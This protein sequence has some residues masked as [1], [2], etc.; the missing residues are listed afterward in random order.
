MDGMRSGFLFAG[1]SYIV[2]LGHA[3]GSRRMGLGHPL[4]VISHRDSALGRPG[5]FL[6]P[7][8]AQPECEGDRQ[9]G[10]QTK[11]GHRILRM[12]VGQVD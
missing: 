8:A 7:A 2:F 6:P 12:V 10:C 3:P 5:A 1:F 9:H 11:P 4:S